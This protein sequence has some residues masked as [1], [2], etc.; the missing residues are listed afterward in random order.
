M[1]WK[2]SHRLSSRMSEPCHLLMDWLTSPSG[3][4]VTR[5]YRGYLVWRYIRY[6]FTD[7]CYLINSDSLLVSFFKAH[8][9]S[10]S[11]TFLISLWL[12]LRKKNRISAPVLTLALLGSW[13]D[14]LFIEDRSVCCFNFLPAMTENL[15]VLA[16]EQTVAFLSPSTSDA[17]AIGFLVEAWERDRQV[18]IQ[19]SA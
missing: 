8:T 12:Q 16:S 10:K 14:I 2:I 5:V 9:I 13:I 6:I 11:H 3:V 17:G 1:R 19:L 7:I 4:E 18:Y 15:F